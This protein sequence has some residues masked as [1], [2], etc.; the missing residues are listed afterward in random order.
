MTH[1]HLLIIY[2]IFNSLITQSFASKYDGKPHLYHYMQC[3]FPIFFKYVKFAL[4]P[5]V[6]LSFRRCSEMLLKSFLTVNRLSMI[7]SDF[8]DCIISLYVA[9]IILGVLMN[10]SM[11]MPI[12]SYTVRYFKVSYCF[13]RMS[14]GVTIIH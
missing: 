12:A 13:N 2:S 4:L 10:F 11:S 1:Q 8:A 14:N 5:T 7:N 9:S 6:F 3:I